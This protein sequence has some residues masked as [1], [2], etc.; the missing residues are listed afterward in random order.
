M[1]DV[2]SK[3]KSR[4]VARLLLSHLDSW[5]RGFQKKRVNGHNAR[6]NF[7]GK[8]RLWPSQKKFS[9]NF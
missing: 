5:N 1:G 8:D 4:F 9:T 3:E 2:G 7:R 6:N